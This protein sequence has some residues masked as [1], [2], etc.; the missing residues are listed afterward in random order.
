MRYVSLQATV[1]MFV[2]GEILEVRRGSAREFNQQ[3][4]QRAVGLELAVSANAYLP[5]I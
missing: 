5:D 2:V 4:L 3:T 1:V